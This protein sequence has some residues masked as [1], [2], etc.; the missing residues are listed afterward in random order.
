MRIVEMT[1]ADYDAFMELMKRIPEMQP[2]EADSREA[3][4]RYLARNAGLSF[5][6]WKGDTLVGCALCGHDGRRGY[7]QHVMVDPL[8]RGQ[9]VAHRL[10]TRCLDGLEAIG[11]LKTHIDVFVTND[12]ANSY[13]PRRGWQRRHDVHRYSF[14]RSADPNA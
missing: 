11:I 13:W 10:V 1:M 5:A 6:A 14:N 4:A 9:G 2:R 8:H 7:L 12:L 3:I